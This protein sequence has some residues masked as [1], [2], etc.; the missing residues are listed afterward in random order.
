MSSRT[1]SPLQLVSEDPE[2]R[3]NLLSR[4]EKE[5]LA[6][7]LEQAE[8]LSAPQTEVLS[9]MQTAIARASHFRHSLAAGSRPQ[10]S[11]TRKFNDQVSR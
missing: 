7:I 4:S 8:S 10:I 6:R 1:L 3:A 5:L 9:L 2:Q 11:I